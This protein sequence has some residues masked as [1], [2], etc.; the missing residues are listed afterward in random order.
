MS[1]A[2]DKKREKLEKLEG[3]M[4]AIR[5][6]YGKGAISPASVPRNPGAERHAPPPGGSKSYGDE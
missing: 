2:Q 6:K 5:A 1:G 3:T 4:D